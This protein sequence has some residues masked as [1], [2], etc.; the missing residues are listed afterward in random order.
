MSDKPIQQTT[1]AWSVRRELWENRSVYLAPVGVAALTQLG[2]L[3]SVWTLP[4]KMK[5]LLAAD[6]T[7]QYHGVVV[8]YDMA[9]GL[10]LVTAFI[11]GIFYCIDALYGER[12]DRSILFWKSL[13]VSD[14]TT[15]LSKAMVPLVIM[16]V[17]VF[18]LVVATHL[19]MLLVSTLVLISSPRS[20]A[21]LW[22][23]L[24]FVQLWIAFGYAVVTIALWHAPIYG[25]MLMVS[26]W[27]KRA[28]FVWAVV[29]LLAVAAVE[30]GAFGTSFVGGL[31]QHRLIGWFNLAFIMPKK[32]EYLAPLM[33][34][35]PE[36]FFSSPGLWIGLILAAIFIAVAIRL[37]RNREPI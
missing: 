1:L 5:S 30:K 32:G 10:T 2:F 21:M 9:A 19:I 17:I 28:T 11:V 16:P 22:A 34:V 35:T 18:I 12:R 27:A 8:H 15:V 4:G 3:M 24:P 20:V 25:W 23:R 6:A 14:V 33:A 29:P 7:K 36:T 37:R 13:P 31:L 26:A